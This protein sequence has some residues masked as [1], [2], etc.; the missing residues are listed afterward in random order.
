[1]LIHEWW[2]KGGAGKVKA[3][4]E[5]MIRRMAGLVLGW[6]ERMRKEELKRIEEGDEKEGQI[7]QRSLS[8]EERAGNQDGVTDA[9]EGTNVP[10]DGSGVAKEAC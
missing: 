1:M 8:K 10:T 5:R 2:K 3:G 4:V 7:A 6:L 9:R